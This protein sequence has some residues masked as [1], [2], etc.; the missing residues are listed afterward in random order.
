M[1]DIDVFRE[2]P[3]RIKKSEKKR[4]N[5]PL[6]IDEI[7]EYDEKWRDAIQRL[8][9][10]RAKRNK[11]DREI[12]ELKK[13]GKDAEEKISEMKE[14][15]KKIDEFEEKEENFKRKRDDMR[16]KIGAILHE[17]VPVGE[18]ENDNVEIRK[19]GEPPE[20]DFE[21]R[22]H[23]EILE[24]LGY[25]DLERGAK[26]AG[27]DFYFLKGDLAL[28]DMAIRR[29]AIDRLSEK[30][31]EVVLPPFM[32][33][34]KVYRAI[35]GDTDDFSEASY[36]VKGKDYWMIPTAEY[37]LGGMYMDETLLESEVPKKM[38]GASACFRRE[39]GA[40]GKYSKGLYR[41]HQFNKVEQFV[42][43][44]PENSWQVFQEL[45]ENAEELYKELGLHYRVVNVCTGDIGAKA[46][47]KYDIECWMADG[48]FHE[49]G[50]NSNCL[51]YQTRELNIKYR[52]G[53]GEKPKDHLH[54]VNN[55]ALATSRTMIS[56]IEQNQ[57]EDGTVTIP[58][59][60]RPYMGGKELLKPRK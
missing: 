54:A 1:I 24:K 45:Q 20:F 26:V 5:D 57:N 23:K 36:A 58:E 19:W 48:D 17:D 43:T 7:V 47:K 16:S 12:G 27:A 6:R 32:V 46:S 10:L 28:L 2:N 42:L 40:R 60:L 50:S 56:I 4:G 25:L 53:K 51:D 37:P 14:V 3:E 31:F 49:T 21:P 30:G 44:L 35:A 22:T 9:D 39:G 38:C 41:V 18:D 34:S 59:A 33:N 11:V 15:N 52:E 13:E 55:T 8:N 29:F